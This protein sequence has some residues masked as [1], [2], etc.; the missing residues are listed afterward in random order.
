MSTP[1]IKCAFNNKISTLPDTSKSK[2]TSLFNKAIWP[3]GFKAKFDITTYWEMDK[4]SC[5]YMLVQVGKWPLL[6]VTCRVARG[7]YKA[8]DSRAYASFGER[9]G[10]I[11]V[12]YMA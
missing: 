1:S 9:V 5:V 12:A 3:S 10:V 4:Y 6:A 8:E 2:P 11:V 7:V